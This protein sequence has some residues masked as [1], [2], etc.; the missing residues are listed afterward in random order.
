VGAAIEAGEAEVAREQLEA[1]CKTEE[2]I[3]ISTIEV[4][5][6]ASEEI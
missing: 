6:T 4:A 5:L 1:V 3:T 2:E